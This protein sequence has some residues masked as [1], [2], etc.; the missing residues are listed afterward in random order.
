VIQQDDLVAGVHPVDED[1]MDILRAKHPK[2]DHL[3]NSAPDQSANK[4]TVQ[5]SNCPPQVDADGWKH[6]LC[7]KLYGKLTESLYVN[8]LQI[9]QKYYAQKKWIHVC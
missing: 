5:P 3:S 8:Q 7:S 9:W 1:I 6:I 4:E 2:P